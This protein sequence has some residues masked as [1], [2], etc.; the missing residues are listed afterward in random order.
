MT[1]ILISSQFPFRLLN[2]LCKHILVSSEPEA[3]IE[4]ELLHP[5]E[6]TQPRCPG[7]SFSIRSRSAEIEQK[8]DFR[9]RDLPADF[10]FGD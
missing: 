9:S 4:P 7:S 5:I 10:D 3:R 8:F 2:G 6:L 1:Y